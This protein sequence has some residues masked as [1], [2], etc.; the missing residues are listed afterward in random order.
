MNSVKKANGY[1]SLLSIILM[2]AHAVYQLVS[3][4]I[5]YYNPVISKVLGYGT[6]ALILIHI[7]LSGFS[8]VRLHDSSSVMYKKLNARTLIQ[9][10]SG[11]LMLILLPIHIYSFKLLGMSVGTIWYWLV[12]ASQVIFFA[13]LYTHVAISFTRALISLGWLTDDRKRASID[14]F[15]IILAPIAAVITGFII[16]RTHLMLF[17]H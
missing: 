3:Y 7:V 4:V 1:I 8:L 5:F 12:E 17:G 2:L 16:V 11:M 14:R 10:G 15:L 13:S 6:A 9:R